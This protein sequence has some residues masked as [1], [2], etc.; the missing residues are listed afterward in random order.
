MTSTYNNAYIRKS[1][2][3]GRPPPHLMNDRMIYCNIPD[4]KV[5]N[6]AISTSKYN[7]V[8]FLPRNILE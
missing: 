5:D 2:F 1:I 4:T 7:L 6:N 3:E 8:T